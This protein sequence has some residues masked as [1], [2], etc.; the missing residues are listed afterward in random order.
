MLKN[1][2]SSEVRISLLGQFL[3]HSEDEFYLRQLSSHFKFSPRSVSLELKNLESIDLIHKRI[4]GKQHYYSVDKQ[5]PLF[6]DLKNIFIKTAGV[7][8]IIAKALNDY[9]SQIEFAFV[10]G[11]FANGNA[12]A[13]S[14]VD[15]M[16]L[17]DVKSRKISGS[18]ISIGEK[19]SREINFSVITVTEFNQRLKDHDHFLTSVYNGPK[20]FIIG[21]LNEFERMGKKWLAETL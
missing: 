12:T 9:V 10:Y 16:I 7:K 21:N 13:R 20:I 15:L 17:G 1:L 5:H 4:S 11:S 2:F 19:L 14:D 6:N 8:D 3:L 18:M